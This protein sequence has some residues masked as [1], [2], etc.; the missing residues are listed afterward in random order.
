MGQVAHT[1]LGALSNL[2]LEEAN[3]DRIVTDDNLDLI[4][5]TIEMHRNVDTV[6]SSAL[7]LIA[8]LS[9]REETAA[10][11]AQ[12]GAVR[13]VVNGLRLH[14]Q[15]SADTRVMLVENGMAALSNLTFVDTFP[16]YILLARGVELLCDILRTEDEDFPLSE[17]DDLPLIRNILE[18]I[19]VALEHA[20]DREK[21]IYSLHQAVSML[22]ERDQMMGEV[23][24]VLLNNPDEEL[25]L[26]VPDYANQRPLDYA[27]L[28]EDPDMV[29]NL[30]CYGSKVTAQT[31]ELALENK[32][33][34][35]VEAALGDYNAMLYA[36]KHTITGSTGL[37]PDLSGV[38]VDYL[39]K[40]E[41]SHF[42]LE[43][44]RGN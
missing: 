32:L 2:A 25:L 39:S 35:V 12:Q 8:N 7:G 6:M 14:D 10:E 24:S 9:I 28:N 33:T 43:P 36:T 44:L 1:V 23:V 19:G 34:D 37:H 26:N 5:S 3:S 15:A 41:L 11:L 4:F 21:N 18:S 16:H 29:Q 13:W 38:V 42:V 30:I 20:Q 17:E 27:I 40:Y 31:R 22:P